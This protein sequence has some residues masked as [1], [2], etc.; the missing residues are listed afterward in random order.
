M[1]RGILAIFLLV[2][3]LS[4]CAPSYTCTDPLGCVE[5]ANGEPILIGAALTLSGP[6]AP[7]GVDALRGVEIAISDKGKLLNHPIELLKEDDQCDA[8]AGEEAAKRLAQNPKLIGVIGETCS[9]GSIPAARILSEAGMVLISPS[10]TAPSLTDPQTRQP[11][12]FRTIYNDKVQGTVAA[13]F[14]F[15]VLGIRTM[16]TL[17][18]GTPY[19]SQL[20]QAACKAFE[21]LGGDC[22]AQI[23][24]Q[25]GSDPKAVL[26][27][28]AV[29][30][31]EALYYPL[32][33][34][35]GV[36]ITR[37]VVEMGLNRLALISGDGLLSTDF[38]RQTSPASNGMYLSGPALPKYDS[39]FLQKYVQRYGEQPLATYNAP[40]YDATM[41]LFNAIE[42]V[43]VRRGNTLYIP[44]QALR[45][46]LAATRDLKGLSGTLTCSPYGDCGVP[47]IQIYQ[48]RGDEFVPIYP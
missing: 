46:A 30:N 34:T 8:Q 28:V 19:S 44:R 9:S 35:D 38:I 25:S 3:V 10:S 32:Y 29:L 13:D 21:E 36:A 39:A 41:M 22:L 15:N 37:A 24:I 14:L 31:P 11:G 23:L 43:A 5:V 27:R 2:F 17:H 12:F 45:E 40:A 26:E 20:Q 33:T 47:A 7:Y 1:K 18:D 4:A 6:D 16:V 42:Q 48:V